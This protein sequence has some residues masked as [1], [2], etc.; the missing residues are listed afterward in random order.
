M[1]VS[2]QTIEP[3]AS[4]LSP[5]DLFVK[6]LCD[7]LISLEAASTGSGRPIACLLTGTTNRGKGKK[8]CKGKK[9]GAIGKLCAVA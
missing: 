4:T 2:D 1:P 3:G 6:E 7:L 8:A 5:D 9:S